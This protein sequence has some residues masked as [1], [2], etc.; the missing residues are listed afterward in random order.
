MKAAHYKCILE[1]KQDY[2]KLTEEPIVIFP[3]LCPSVDPSPAE[4]ARVAENSLLPTI[5]TD[6]NAPTTFIAL[7]RTQL[8]CMLNASN[9]AVQSITVGKNEPAFSFNRDLCQ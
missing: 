9:K 3:S 4:L 5:P 6:P 8:E 2:L 7:T 1:H